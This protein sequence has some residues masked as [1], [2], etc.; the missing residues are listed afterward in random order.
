MK[1][2]KTAVILAWLIASG[3]LLVLLSAPLWMAE[4]TIVGATH[5]CRSAYHGAPACSL[6]GMTRAFLF[7]SRG[8]FEQASTANHNSVVLFG[9]LVLN[10]IIALSYLLKGYRRVIHSP[11]AE[12]TGKIQKKP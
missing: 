6:C 8:D 10:E 1:Q 2:I 4:G 9:S 5:L 12:M 3:F 11:S 7:I